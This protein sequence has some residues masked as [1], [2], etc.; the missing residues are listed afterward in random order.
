MRTNWQYHRP[1]VLANLAFRAAALTGFALGLM[2]AITRDAPS[3][4]SCDVERAECV[5]RLI[6][7]EALV[8]VTP[9]VV[10]LVLGMIVGAWMARAVHAMHARART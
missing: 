8:H 3:G 7:H 2:A 4:P 1:H 5:A 6:R 9:P 10:G